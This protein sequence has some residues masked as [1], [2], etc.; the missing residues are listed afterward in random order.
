L[1]GGRTRSKIFF[2]RTGKWSLDQKW[3]GDSEASGKELKAEKRKWGTEETF[4]FQGRTKHINRWAMKV[5]S[6]KV[7]LKVAS[8][9][10]SEISE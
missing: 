1:S 9:G 7:Q 8:S 3:G 6:A 5:A 2:K 4:I 10:R